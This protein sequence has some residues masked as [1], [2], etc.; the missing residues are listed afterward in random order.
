MKNVRSLFALFA[1]FTV[2]AFAAPDP[3]KDFSRYLDHFVDRTVDPGQDFFRYAV[4]TWLKNNPIP[5]NERSWGI[6]NVVREETYQRMLKIN[7]SASTGSK[8]PTGSNSQKIGDFWFAAMDT[9]AIEKA[10]ITPLKTEF[11]RIDAIGNLQELI[12][13][14]ARLHTIGA[15]P[16]FSIYIFQDEKD[17]KRYALHLYQGG[18]GLPDRDYYFDEDDRT[19]KIRS[20][21]GKHLVKMFQLLGD[22]AAKAQGNA[23]VVVRLETD[24]AKSSRKLAD[25]RDSHAN[26]NKMGMEDLFK[27]TPSLDWKYFFEKADIKDLTTVI[28]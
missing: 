16:A 24:L 19:K 21:Y 17:S 26:Y 20:E 28:V 18:L 27:L 7:E 8:A 15:S 10:G 5:S 22:T 25:L 3:S 9:T 2:L 23:D 12:D 1:I 14:A 4:G 6:G 11:D 13:V